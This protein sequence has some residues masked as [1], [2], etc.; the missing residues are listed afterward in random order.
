MPQ[1][2]GRLMALAASPHI[3]MLVR[4]PIG[5][6]LLYRFLNLLPTLKAPSFEGQR[7]ECLPPRFDQVQI[8]RSSRLQDELPARIG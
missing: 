8:G 7:I 4:I 5:R 1:L 6:R 3:G 2:A